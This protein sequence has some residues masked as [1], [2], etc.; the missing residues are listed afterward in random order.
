MK[1]DSSPHVSRLPKIALCAWMMVVPSLIAIPIPG[2]TSPASV[3]VLICYNQEPGDAQ[4][5]ELRLKGGVVY[6]T[7]R[8]VPA[9]AA[10][11]PHSA[12]N[13]LRRKPEIRAV[14]PDGLV[15]AHGESDA[16]WG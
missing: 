11:V 2:A 4:I 12:L 7:F 3:D 10:R 14:E 13:Y 16:A 5:E 6:R 15:E 9:V 8:I 1:P